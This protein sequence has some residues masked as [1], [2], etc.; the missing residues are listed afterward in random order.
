MRHVLRIRNIAHHLPTCRA[1]GPASRNCCVGGI[2]GRDN[3]TTIRVLWNP[4]PARAEQS[5]SVGLSPDALQHPAHPHLANPQMSSELR[6]RCEWAFGEHPAVYLLK[7]CVIDPSFGPW[8]LWP[9][10]YQS[11][12]RKTPDGFLVEAQFLHQTVAVHAN[13][14]PPVPQIVDFDRDFDK[15]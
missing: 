13:E 14:P 9:G 1:T 8:L 5:D 11:C 10:P 4:H 15:E 7:C 12:L 6:L 3:M 2:A